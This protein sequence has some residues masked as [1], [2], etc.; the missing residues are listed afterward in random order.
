MRSAAMGI[1]EGMSRSGALKALTI[2][3]AVMLDLAD[4]IGSL[5]TGK[6]ADFVI[7]NGDPF[8]VYTQVEQTWVEGVKRFDIAIPADRAFAIGGYGVFS[9]ERAEHHA[10]K[11]LD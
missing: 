6:D 9:P 5:E 10:H 7:L 4:R 3:G 11:Q 1:R 8:S 2:N